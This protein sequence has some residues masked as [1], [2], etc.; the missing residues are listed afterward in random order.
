MRH[1]DFGVQPRCAAGILVPVKAR[2]VATGD[3]DA[4]LVPHLEEI[5]CFPEYNLVSADG[6]GFDQR[7]FFIGIAESRTHNAFADV[8]G[9]PPGWTSTSVAV[10]SV[11]GAVEAA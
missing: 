10:K 3:F 1:L 6:F 9:F 8:N 5:A 11:S 2:E 4:N 7:W